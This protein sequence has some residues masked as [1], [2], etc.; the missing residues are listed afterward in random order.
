MINKEIKHY[1]YVLK[2]SDP[3]LNEE[4]NWTDKQKK[5]T[6]DHFMYLKNLMSDNV[7]IVAGRSIEENPFGIVVFKAK[8]WD[9]A[10]QIM[11]D[12][13]AVKNIL[14]TAELHE[15]SLSLLNNNYQV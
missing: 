2:L 3:K 13:P 7:L 9:D 14:M 11:N 8:T 6:A 10:L 15:F 5:I 12:D 4:S 1:I